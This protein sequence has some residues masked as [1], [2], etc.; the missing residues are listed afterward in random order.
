MPPSGAQVPVEALLKL[1][2][3]KGGA[4][5]IQDFLDHQEKSWGRIEQTIGRMG[6]GLEGVTRTAMSLA[7]IAG[8]GAIANNFLQTSTAGSNVGLAAGRVTGGANVW[9]PY[10]Q[11]LLTDQRKTGVQATSIAEGLV[12]AVQAVGGQPTPQ[13]AQ[14]LGGLLAGVSQTEGLSPSQVSS[15][16]APMLQAAHKPLSATGAGSTIATIQQGLSQFPGSQSSPMLGLISALATQQAL[17]GGSA[18]IAGT[19][20][21]I[22]AAA[23]GNSI[24]RNP[25]AL[26]GAISGISSGMQ[27]AFGNPSQEA[28]LQMAGVGYY[29][30]RGGLSNPET[31][32]KIIAEATR[33]YGTGITRDIALRS[34]FGL[35]GADLLETYAKHPGALQHGLNAYEHPPS[36]EKQ[37]QQFFGQLNHNQARTTPQSRINQ[38]SGGI[39]GWIEQNFLTAALGLGGIAFGPKLLRGG[40]G[41][42]GSLFRGGAGS[43]AEDAAAASAADSAGGGLLGDLALSSLGRIAL[44]GLGGGVGSFGLSML[45]PDS[46]SAPHIQANRI[47]QIAVQ[48]ALRYGRMKFG[49]HLNTAAARNYMQQLIYSGGSDIYGLATENA[50]GFTRGKYAPTAGKLLDQM[51]GDQYA[52][53]SPQDPASKLNEAADKLMKAADKLSGRSPTSYSPGGASGATYVGTPAVQAMGAVAPGMEFAALTGASGSFSV[54]VSGPASGGSSSFVSQ[55]GGQ[56]SGGGWQDCLLT[57][58]QPSAGGINGHSGGGACGIPIYDSTWGCAAPPQYPC[59]TMIQFLIGGKVWNV[60]VIDRGGA[61]TGNHF[62]LNYAVAQKTGFLNT[63]MGNAKFR[64]AGRASSS[65]SSSSGGSGGGNIVSAMARRGAPTGRG[66]VGSSPGGVSPGGGCVGCGSGGGAITPFSGGLTPVHGGHPTHI[67]LHVDG[68]EIH[69]QRLLVGRH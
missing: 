5:T 25:S 11:A 1:T 50:G 55:T 39:M 44:G 34:M 68:R 4:Q 46:I 3:D 33:L 20:A 43:A 35:S 29:E 2:L 49:S 10:A 12:A 62:D 19:T 66:G 65:S 40:L 17:G 61:I 67:H 31:A 6:D 13:Q 14:I 41:K 23:A 37:L 21:L 15:I 47:E 7:G 64:V 48:N 63:G 27:G 24:W 57:Y 32:R 45:F 8:I 26:G 60:P 69:R 30:Q 9:H 38:A 56:P 22:N 16:L 52:P 59:G 51:L 18:N 58:Y 28:F 53:G 54:P 42:L 36:L